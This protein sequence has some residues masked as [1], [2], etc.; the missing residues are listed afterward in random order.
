MHLGAA[1]V[2]DWVGALPRFTFATTPSITE[3]GATVGQPPSLG[4]DRLVAGLVVGTGAVALRRRGWSFLS[5]SGQ[6]SRPVEAEAVGAVE[7]PVES[8][9][10]R[11]EA[12][13]REHGGRMRQSAIVAATGWSKSKVSMLLSEMEETDR[14]RKLR[15]G[16]EN[17]VSLPGAE[18]E[19]VRGRDED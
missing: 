1:L 5:R 9:E 19:A 3:L 12:L 11:V 15:V 7:E 13:L 16:R 10:A 2:G 18:P 8:D 6:S 4:V 14:V 17:L